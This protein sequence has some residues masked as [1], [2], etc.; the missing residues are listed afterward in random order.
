MK[1]S[2]RTAIKILTKRLIEDIKEKEEK[3]NQL[4]IE[5]LHLI[6]GELKINIRDYRKKSWHLEATSSDGNCL[7]YEFIKKRGV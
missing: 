5:L 4:R 3:L 7:V 6:T 1:P 2:K